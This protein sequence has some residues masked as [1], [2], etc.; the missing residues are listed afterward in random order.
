MIVVHI[1]TQLERNISIIEKYLLYLMLDQYQLGLKKIISEVIIII[2]SGQLK[3]KEFPK[4]PGIYINI[5]GV[6]KTRT[7][8]RLIAS[9]GCV[10]PGV[11][12]HECVR[13][14]DVKDGVGSTALLVHICGCHCARFIS[15]RH[16]RLD[17]L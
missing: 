11:Q 12:V 7:I 5:H 16:Q 9:R 4:E 6:I 8:L 1:P 14:D 2:V 13:Q 15:L 3:Q 17:V 10:Y